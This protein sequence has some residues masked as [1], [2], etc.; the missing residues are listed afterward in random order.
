MRGTVLVAGVGL[1]RVSVT[2]LLGLVGQAVLR[3]V[4]TRATVGAEGLLAAAMVS[5]IQS[6]R[7]V[8]RA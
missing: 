8:T 1:V 5:R 3:V 4:E 2:K 7:L 6:R